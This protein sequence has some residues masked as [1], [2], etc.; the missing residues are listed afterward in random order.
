MVSPSPA[1][2]PSPGNVLITGAAKR[3]GQA[4]ALDLANIGWGVAIHYNRSSGDAHELVRKITANGGR[5]VPLQ[6]DLSDMDR[7]KPLMNDAGA[8]LGPITT[9]INNASLFAPDDLATLTPEGWAAH[10]DIN[11]RAPVFLA[12]AFAAALPAGTPGNII[13]MIDQRVWRLTPRFLSY[14]TA[15]AGLWTLTQTL[16]QALAPQIRVNGIGPGP[17]LSN[18]R[19]SEADF[20]KQTAATLLGSGPSLEEICATVRFILASSALTGQMIALDGGQHL[21]WE[22][23]DATG[24]E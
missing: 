6:A 17:T 5:A 21:A 9:L 2:T 14:T 4:L 15:K 12:Q 22:T 13:N 8:A 11:L 19:Q 20:R 10:M 16:A 7:L 3:I 18:E 23:P 1:L 24:L